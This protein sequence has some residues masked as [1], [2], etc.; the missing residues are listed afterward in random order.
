MVVELYNV[1]RPHSSLER[2]TPNEKYL[3]VLLPI[4]PAA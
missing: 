1:H 3:A 2:I 4:K